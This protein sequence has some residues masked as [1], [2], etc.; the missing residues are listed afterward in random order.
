MCARS[1]L[2]SPTFAT[3][4]LP[5]SRIATIARLRDEAAFCLEKTFEQG[6]LLVAGVATISRDQ[7]EELFFEEVCAAG[8][9]VSV[10]EAEQCAVVFR[11]VVL[12]ADLLDDAHPVFVVLPDEALVRLD[13]ELD[14]RPPLSADWLC[15]AL[16]LR[17][18][19]SWLPARGGG[20][21][22]LLELRQVLS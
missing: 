22:F 13:A 16:F 5:V 8:P 10:E 20:Q 14:E 2:E 12:S 21:W 9:T 11:R 15:S 7:A 17:A 4:S 19:L 1:A 6:T 18:R 3:V